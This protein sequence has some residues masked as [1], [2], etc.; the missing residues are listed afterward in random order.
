[1]SQDIHSKKFK[2]LEGAVVC[3]WGKLHFN[4]QSPQCEHEIVRENNE[5]I[6]QSQSRKLKEHLPSFAKPKSLRFFCPN[7]FFRGV[8]SL[9]IDTRNQRV[10]FISMKMM[11][12]WSS[13]RNQID[14]LCTYHISLLIAEVYQC[15]IVQLANQNAAMHQRIF[16]NLHNMHIFLVG[17]FAFLSIDGT[18]AQATQIVDMK[19][20]LGSQ[21][22]ALEVLLQSTPIPQER[23]QHAYSEMQHGLQTKKDLFT[24]SLVDAE[25]RIH[26][27]VDDHSRVFQQ[28]FA[29][30]Q[31]YSL[32]CRHFPILKFHGHNFM[33]LTGLWFVQGRA[34]GVST[35]AFIYYH[36]PARQVESLELAGARHPTHWFLPPTFLRAA[37]L[38]I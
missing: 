28:C 27:W 30:R 20:Q 11:G 14:A 9:R 31:F 36:H 24:Q 17:L 32:S 12:L 37:R 26:N 21:M 19:E 10:N 2:D 38:G 15:R 3:S 25:G 18:F 8:H 4:K 29:V 33:Y 7:T 22:H 34:I 16:S 13:T 1:V 6:R 23:I 35:K 5:G